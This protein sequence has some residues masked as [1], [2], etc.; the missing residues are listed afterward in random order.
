[1]TKEQ[2]KNLFTHGYNQE[3]WKLLMMN[4]LMIY[5]AM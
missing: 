3:N 1:M 5:K 4:I 2:I